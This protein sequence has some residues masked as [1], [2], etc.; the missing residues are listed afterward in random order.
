LVNDLH[1]QAGGLGIDFEIIVMEDGSDTFVERNQRISSLSHCKYIY[2]EQNTGRSAIRNRLADLAQYPYLLF[3]DCDAAVCNKDFLFRYLPFCQG[4]VVVIGGTAYDRGCNNPSYSLRLKY[5]RERESN[6]CYLLKN[7]EKEHDNV[8]N[9]TTFNFLISKSVF[10]RI[11]FDESISGYGH[12]DTIFGHSLHVKGFVFQR[13][14][15]PLI[16]KGLDDNTTY[17]KKT[18]ESVKNLYRLYRLGNYPFLAE[19]SKLLRTFLKLK[20]YHLTGLVV[21]KF[22][23]VRKM[24]EKNLT[25]KHPDLLVYDLYKLFLLCKYHVSSDKLTV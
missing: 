21:L 8:D 9:F 20:K 5:G 1:L 19:E 11:R 25:G 6:P 14:D 2:L 17:L 24:M 4:E 23:F 22:M 15:N 3:M 10:N 13:I 7:H 16:H 18:S 12:E